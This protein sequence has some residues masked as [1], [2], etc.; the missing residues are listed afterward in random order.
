[1][2][3]IHRQQF[4]DE[5]KT[6]ST[7]I[8]DLHH[9]TKQSHMQVNYGQTVEKLSKQLHDGTKMNYYQTQ[10]EEELRESLFRSRP[11]SS[12]VITREKEF[13]QN[14]TSHLKNEMFVNDR[15]RHFNK[16]Q[17]QKSLAHEVNL[18]LSYCC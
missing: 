2:F 9:T 5:Q 1:M 13:L 7:F 14:A 4:R 10:K 18:C 8:K 15:K 11:K 6:I 17:Q 3:E 12:N 16:Y